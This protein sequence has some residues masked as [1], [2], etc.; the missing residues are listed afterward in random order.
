MGTTPEA[1]GCSPGVAAPTGRDVATRGTRSP[2]TSSAR[3]AR[4]RCAVTTG[5]VATAVRR[6]RS[7]SPHAALVLGEDAHTIAIEGSPVTRRTYV[8]DTSVLL[9]DPRAMMRFD[10]HEVVLPLVVLTELEAQAQPP[11]AGL[12]RPPGAAPARG[13]AHAARLAHRARC[14]STTRAARCGSRSTTRTSA[15]CPPALPVDTNDHRILAVARNLGQRGPRRRRRHQGPAAAPEGRASSGSRPRST[16]TSSP[17][18]TGWTGFVELDVDGTIIDELFERHGSS[19]STEARDLP[20]HTGVALHAGSQSALA[21]VHPDKRAAP[22]AHRPASCSTCA[23]ARP[24]SAS[25]S[26]CSPTP[27]IGIV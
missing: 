25:P 18:D 7:A 21:R 8:L 2:S 27:T 20:C 15:A 11:R 12:G 13:P 22:G 23:A 16:A 19:T 6:S 17:R 9:A 14:R 4:R 24:S 26:T 10:E 3:Q 5:S 1:A